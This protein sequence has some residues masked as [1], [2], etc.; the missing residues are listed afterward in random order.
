M[1]CVRVKKEALEAIKQEKIK[2][3]KLN[4]RL[5]NGKV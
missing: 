1:D 4:Q 2:K 5:T 3:I